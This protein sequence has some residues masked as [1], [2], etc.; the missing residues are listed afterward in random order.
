MSTNSR[1]V[2][3]GV[4]DDDR[5]FPRLDSADVPTMPLARGKARSVTESGRGLA[6]VEG[7]A[8][9]WGI[10]VLRCGKQEWARLLLSQGPTR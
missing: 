8:D 7:L 2:K 5:H 6:I 1:S 3:L 9:E 4:R 10:D